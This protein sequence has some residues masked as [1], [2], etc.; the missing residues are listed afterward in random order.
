ML[1]F[2]SYH[3]F[4]MESTFSFDVEIL[5]EIIVTVSLI[6]LIVVSIYSNASKKIT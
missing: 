4:W 3:Y 6:D 2:L 5:N 1:D